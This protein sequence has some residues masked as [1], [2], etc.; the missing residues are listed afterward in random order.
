MERRPRA[1]LALD[2]LAGDRA[3]LVGEGRVDVLLFTNSFLGS[4]RIFFSEVSSRS[5][6]VAAAGGAEAMVPS[7]ILNIACCTPSP[8]TSRVIE[9]LSDLRL[10]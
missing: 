10:I 8:D 7:M 1:G 9:G 3:R 2:R 5:S 6:S 4:V